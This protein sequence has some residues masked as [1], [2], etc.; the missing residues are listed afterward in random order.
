MSDYHR[1]FA[2][3]GT[4][5]FT[6]VTYNRQPLLCDEMVLN[7][8]KASFRYAISKRPFKIKG[9][10]ILPDHLHCVWQL[11]DNDDNFS[12]RWN[13]IK[14]YFSIGFQGPT[15][16]RREKNIWQRRFWEHLIRD[17]E[18]LN[19]CLDYIHYNPVKHGYVTR[20]CDWIQSTFLSHVKQGHYD[21]HWGCGEVP[22]NLNGYL[23][24]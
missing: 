24:E 5:F 8:L 15:N 16:K 4:Y 20:P 2:K 3:G 11:P 23:L 1:L 6:V 13:M 17:E 14:R 21:M 19:Q 9:M 18:S 12:I 7:R 10:V 22:K